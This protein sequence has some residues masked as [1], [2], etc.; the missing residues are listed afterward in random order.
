MHIWPKHVRIAGVAICSSILLALS[1]SAQAARIALVIGNADYAESRLRNPVNDAKAIAAKLT[2][3]G[4]QVLLRENLKQKQLGRIQRELRNAIRPG[5]DVVF[6]YAGHGLQIKGVNY[7]PVVDAEIE[8]E[9]DVPTQSI[10]VNGILD[11][12]EDA[13][14]GI[15]LVFLDACRNNPFERRLRSYRGYGGGLAKIDDVATGSLI[16]FATRP[17]SVA[18]DGP[19]KNGLYTEYLLK[20]LGE[21]DLPVEQML[22]HVADDV[23]KASGGRQQPWIEGRIHGDFYFKPAAKIAQPASRD[24]RAAS[25]TVDPTLI[26]LRFWE[27]IQSSSDPAEFQ[28]YLNKY[29][30]GQFAALANSRISRLRQPLPAQRQGGRATESSSPAPNSPTQP[31]AP[32]SPSTTIALASSSANR[33]I[34]MSELDGAWG[35]TYHCDEWVVPPSLSSSEGPLSTEIRGSISSGRILLVSEMSAMVQYRED[36][37][38]SVSPDLSGVI[39]GQS[40]IV[41]NPQLLGVR[42]WE[43]SFVVEFRRDPSGA[44]ILAAQGKRIA[45]SRERPTPCTISLQKLPRVER[46]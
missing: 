8:G 23:E 38:G 45:S 1:I 26:E 37:S 32:A 4:F 2:D 3:L 12:L 21:A 40:K 16:S 13:K 29:P 18:D 43:S 14:A 27:S 46:R 7:L 5:D 39:K 33:T 15:R 28:A 30:N 36:L 31:A 24:S 19:G 42:A 34:T 22:K 10:N 35:G 44:I 6:F 17:G 41:N 25:E 11:L 9:E 20:R